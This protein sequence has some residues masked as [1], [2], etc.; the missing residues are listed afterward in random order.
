MRYRKVVNPH[1]VSNETSKILR[2]LG[3]DDDEIDAVIDHIRI[4]YNVHVYN[5]AAPFVSKETE[6][7]NI[8]LYGFGVKFCNLQHGWNQRVYIG[9]T[10]W[11]KNIYDAKRKAINIAIKWILS[12]KSQEKC[13]FICIKKNGT[14]KTKSN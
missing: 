1:F 7:K 6:T 4:K 8:V 14:S 13:K 9:K 12:H 11:I 2:T 10:P 5:Y 3:I